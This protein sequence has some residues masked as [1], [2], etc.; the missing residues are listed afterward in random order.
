M[1]TGIDMLFVMVITIG[2]NSLTFDHLTYKDLETCQ[3][4]ADKVFWH[5]R[6]RE[7]PRGVECKEK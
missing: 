7:S 5:I 2:A 3:Y 1:A 6:L 4:H